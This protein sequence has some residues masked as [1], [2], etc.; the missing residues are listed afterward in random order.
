[1]VKTVRR[2]AL[3]WLVIAVIAA[4]P[5]IAL[6][7][8]VDAAAGAK[9]SQAGPRKTPKPAAT[10]TQPPTAAPTILP[11]SVPTA[12]P[13]AVL[14]GAG[15]IASCSSSGDEA[16]AAVLA[17]VSGTVFTL[18]DNVYDNGTPTEYANCYGPSWGVAS[19][20]S[21]TKPVAGNHEYNTLNATGYYGYF[22][23][24]AGD[25][26]KGYYAYDHGSWRVY[27]LNSNC[28][29][30][31]GCTAGSPQETWLRG[32]LTNNPRACVVA[33]WHHPLYS[34]GEHGN[35]TATQALYQTLYDFNA[36]LVLVGHDHDYERFA[37]QDANGNLDNGRGIVEM[38]VGTGGRSHYAFTTIRANSLVRN[39]TSY[40]VLRLALSNGSWASQFL[41][42]AGQTFSDSGSGT[43]H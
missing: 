20:K 39:G 8:R 30:I 42:V 9:P 43:C 22:G 2:A 24:A 27:V 6:G 13:P 35:S 33:M 7:A 34:S 1:M 10:P 14:V 16:T 32:D 11:T 12:P 17:T 38:V 4:V 31:G 36:E 25:P 19:I 37:P 21:R 28:A 23:A 15:D 18:G 3:G 29:S 41:P 26:T 40:G 5:I